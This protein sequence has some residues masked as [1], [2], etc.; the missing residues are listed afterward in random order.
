MNEEAQEV[1]ASDT[2]SDRFPGHTWQTEL[3][4]ASCP[5]AIWSAPPQDLMC[6]AQ[7]FCHFADTFDFA[8]LSFL[9]VMLGQNLLS[10]K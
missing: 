3:I 9:L 7:E 6:A 2:K 5:L 4:H 8:K 10:M 1:K